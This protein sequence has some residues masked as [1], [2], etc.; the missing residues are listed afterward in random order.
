MKAGLF[1]HVSSSAKRLATL[2]FDAY[3]HN[4]CLAVLC[5]CLGDFGHFGKEMFFLRR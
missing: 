1:G 4:H 2:I 3:N 5:K